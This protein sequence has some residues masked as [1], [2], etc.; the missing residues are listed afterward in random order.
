MQDVIQDAEKMMAQMS[1]QKSKG[2]LR[3][4]DPATGPQPNAWS[5]SVQDGGYQDFPNQKWGCGSTNCCYSPGP[6]KKAIPE[7]PGQKTECS[8]CVCV[9]PGPRPE[10]LNIVAGSMFNRLIM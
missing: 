4:Y 6:V 3:A 8:K 7:E 10:S 5:Y 2:G 1:L 9:E